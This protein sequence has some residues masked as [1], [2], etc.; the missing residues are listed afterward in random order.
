MSTSYVHLHPFYI[1][2]F[3]SLHIRLSVLQTHLLAVVTI[4]GL[5]K[6]FAR[7]LSPSPRSSNETFS[8]FRGIMKY[9]LYLYL[10]SASII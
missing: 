1:H 9:H 6:G 2:T 4:E 7:F 5:G 8:F 10:N 3:V